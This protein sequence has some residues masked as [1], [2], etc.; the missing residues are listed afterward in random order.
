MGLYLFGLVCDYLGRS[1][2]ILVG[3]RLSVYVGWS[4][5]SSI[6]SL[7]KPEPRQKLELHAKYVDILIRVSQHHCSPV[8]PLLY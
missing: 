3:L 8:G 1:V 7:F 5:T 4:V 2:S 6:Y